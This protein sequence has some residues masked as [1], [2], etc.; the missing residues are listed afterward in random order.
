MSG[1]TRRRFLGVTAG[2]VG[3]GALAVA[4]PGC[5]VLTQQQAG[6]L[7]KSRARL[8]KPFTVPLPIPPVA[9]PT[10]R[11]P[12]AWYY[13]IPV[14][15]AEAE[16]LPGLKTRIYGY[17]GIFPGPTIVSRRDR[18]TVVRHSN[19]L[20]VPIAVHLHGGHTPHGSDGYP[21]DLVLPKGG[22]PHDTMPGDIAHGSRA[23]VYPM[24]QRA[25]T[26]W[27]HDHRMDFTGPQ[28]YRGLAGFHLV[29]DD[30]EDA[31][32][33]PKG[34]RDIPLLICDRSFDA[35]GAFLYPALDP[36]L[37]AP[38]GVKEAYMDGVL[39]DV[40]LVNGAPW[41][42][43]EVTATRYR[44]RIL[45]A[46]SARRY[47]LTLDPQPS[48]G[49]A[50]VQVGS[51]G[52]LLA[53]PNPLDRVEIAQAER[54]DVVVDFSRFEVGSTVTMTNGF[55]DGGT[56]N[57]MR[58]RV[59][60]KAPDDSAVPKRLGDLEVLRTG[61]AKVTRRFDFQ[62][63]TLHGHQAWLINGKPFDPDR[64]DAAPPLGQVERWRFT[65]DIR[66]P[67]HVHLDP[68]QVLGGGDYRKGWKDTVDMRSGETVDVLV[69]FSDYAGKYVLH[70]HNLEHE[71]M[72]MMANFRTHAA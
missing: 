40:V 14:R 31:L 71:D 57:V 24:R 51:D 48:G 33:L 32:P 49:K 29:H 42:E 1:L 10:R 56:K 9:E 11:T 5:S 36:K 17:D 70:C 4:L 44:F 16:I 7:L 43:L 50:F 54:F 12:D 45:N 25:M 47:Q 13:D 23:Y 53:G 30:E 69:R 55:G 72:A 26:L 41:P 18:R 19:E 60:R 8:P 35:D 15:E 65:T 58:F 39:G 64:I 66:H 52:G 63:G 2:A 37:V 59:A 27:Y 68:F 46:S 6:E 20:P 21:T 61:Q 62:Q 34:E 38:P 28:V 3:L 22:W 67:I